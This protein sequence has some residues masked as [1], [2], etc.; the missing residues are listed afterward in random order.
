MTDNKS[1]EC[2]AAPKLIFSCSG[3]ADV[4]EISDKVA[5]QLTKEGVGNMY[6]LAGI[7]GRVSGIVKSTEA[8]SDILVIDGCKLDCAR[9]CLSEVGITSITHVRITDHGFDKGK[10]EVT[11]ENVVKVLNICQRAKS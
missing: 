5:R 2:C 3:A 7:G 4:G 6:C 11:D 9:K 10:T 8:A 1:C